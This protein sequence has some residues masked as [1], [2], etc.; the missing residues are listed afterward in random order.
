MDQSREKVRFEDLG[1]K[2]LE[3]YAQELRQL[4]DS[5]RGLREGLEGATAQLREANEG[6]KA[7]VS[8]RTQ[9]EARAN[10]LNEELGRRVAERTAELTGA[11][12]ELEATLG[13]LR[14]TQQQIVQQE[15]MRAL[16]QMS[17]G[18]A[19][20]FNNALSIILSA[21]ELLLASSEALKDE[22]KLKHYL[23]I[24]RTAAEDASVTV[25]RLKDFYREPVQSELFHPIDLNEV[26]E[27]TVSLTEPRWIEQTQ[28][29][30]IQIEV[31]AD[32]GEVPHAAS[33][34]SEIREALTNLILNAADAMPE[35]GKITIRSRL[36][37]SKIALEV[38]D[39]GTG[40]TEDVRRR[41]MDPFFT[42]KGEGG[43]GMGL[44]M[45]FGIVQRH[46]GTVQVES[47]VGSG[48]AITIRLP[49]GETTEFREAE[50]KAG[51]RPV[52]ALKVLVVD[53][54]PAV[55]M[56]HAEILKADGHSVDTA[57]TGRIALEKFRA[58]RH[59]LV[60]TDRAMPEMNGDEL[61]AAI[62]KLDPAKSVVMVTG[63]GDVMEMSGDRPE[64]ADLVLSKPVSRADLR[65]AV[66]KV[67]GHTVGQAE[68]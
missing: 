10:Q 12:S 31:E 6:L 40:M 68:R 63:F 60:M 18:I 62:K 36:D 49:V 2:Q 57:L 27:Q 1:R 28:V 4:F 44:A 39:T 54:D 32:L 67:A 34:E 41:C 45:V 30:G 33:N 11:N 22:A 7:E 53:D 15:R 37:G 65:E 61:A 23:Q 50:A 46:Q 51:I 26:I 20:D 29:R 59:D 8:K 42:T 35:G 9:A 5:E 43:T 47:E 25:K 19:H 17:S 13:E 3:I 52:P 55:L 66:I 21:T 24:V 38:R 58:A 14:K 64:H 56:M 48:T 16:G